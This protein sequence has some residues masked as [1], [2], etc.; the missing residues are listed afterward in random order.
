[1]KTSSTTSFPALE[2]FTRI[3]LIEDS[4]E[5]RDILASQLK[6]IRPRTR[7]DTPQNWQDLAHLLFED[8]Q[9]I[10]EPGSILFITDNSLNEGAFE[11]KI[12]GFTI[13]N[14]YDIVMHLSEKH[15]PSIL[16]SGAAIK[17]GY[18]IKH[19][20]D[21]NIP[22]YFLEGLETQLKQYQATYIME[23]TQ[24]FD[25][26]NTE[27]APFLAYIINRFIEH[28]TAFTDAGGTIFRNYFKPEHEPVN[29]LVIRGSYNKITKI[30]AQN[31][32]RS[33]ELDCLS[34][35]KG[36]AAINISSLQPYHIY[37]YIFFITYT[38]NN[39]RNLR[40]TPAAALELAERFSEEIKELDSEDLDFITLEFS[41]MLYEWCKLNLFKP[42]DIAAL[43][44]NLH[45]LNFPIIEQIRY[46]IIEFIDNTRK[47]VTIRNKIDLQSS[48]I[49]T[50]FESSIPFTK[51]NIKTN[52]SFREIKYVRNG[53][54]QAPS[55]CR[56][57]LTPAEQF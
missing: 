48:R 45:T 37:K 26:A 7:I 31:N 12:D 44:N 20:N 5:T 55:L 28:D 52:D 38:F 18:K 16:Y 39:I 36:L 4:L 29:G 21:Q 9:K 46:G 54:K 43:S 27:F 3:I 14:G 53:K 34:L 42:D 22:H 50:N 11:N 30:I 47:Q 56:Y 25:W 49:I 24:E 33:L 10:K 23:P 6:K 2:N 15:I 35:K 1:M 13:E 32:Y 57:E 41:C 19:L 40:K 51:L 8:I 17:E